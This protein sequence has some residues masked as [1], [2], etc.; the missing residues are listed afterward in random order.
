[1]TE[2]TRYIAKI[3]QL[4]RAAADKYV[5][6]RESL[7]F[8]LLKTPPS[9]PTVTPKKI[10]TICQPEDFLL[11]IGSEELPATFVPTGI[12]QLESLA[13]KLLADYG[14]AYKHLEVLGTPRRLALCIEGLSH[15][16]I[17]P[18]SEKKGPLFP[19][20]L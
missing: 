6:W 15:V 19:Y 13:K 1:M 14:I 5:A 2:R 10:P 18:E 17:R 9:T 20:Y 3:R 8:P 16:T 4:A 11:E 7:G 12:Q